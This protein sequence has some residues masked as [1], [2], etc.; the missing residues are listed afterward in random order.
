MRM[1]RGHGCAQMNPSRTTGLPP[2]ALVISAGGLFDRRV[3]PRSRSNHGI[4]SVPLGD[5]AVLA[6]PDDEFLLVC[7][8]LVTHRTHASKPAS[9][10]AA[11]HVGITHRSDSLLREEIET[12]RE[13]R[14][15][16]NQLCLH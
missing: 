3:C 16:R 6:G 2:P 9:F 7:F 5:V 11:P 14:R 10:G 4:P 8:A 13:I 1:L 12:T 15:R